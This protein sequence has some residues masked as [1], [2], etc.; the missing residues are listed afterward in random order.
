MKRFIF[1]VFLLL[2]SACSFAQIDSPDFVDS[3]HHALQ[4]AKDTDRVIILGEL[5]V[6]YA[7]YKPDSSFNFAKEGLQLSEQLHYKK[8]IAIS[9]IRLAACFRSTGS[10]AQAMQYARRALPIF[11]ELKDVDNVALCNLMMNWVYFDQEM[12][13]SAFSYT[14]KATNLL[15]NTNSYMLYWCYTSFMRLYY[16]ENMLDSVIVYAE[17]A[18]NVSHTIDPLQM[19]GQVYTQKHDTAKAITYYKEALS[20]RESDMY[21][22]H[23]AQLKGNNDSAVFYAKKRLADAM[24]RK[25]LQ[26]VTNA[27]AFLF[28]I[29]SSEHKSDS[30]LK[31]ILIS[32]HAKDSLFS[33]EK[34]RQFQTAVYS[35]AM[36]RQEQI[37]QQESDASKRKI[38]I[39]ISIAAIIILIAFFL[40]RSNRQKQKANTLLY[41]QKNEIEQQRQKAENAL[42]E[43]KS[44]QT[45]LIQSEKMASL[46]ELTAGIAH[47]IQNPLNFVNN[48]SEVNKEMVDELQLE[49]KSGNIEDAIAISNDIKENSEK[50]NHHGKRADAIVKNMLQHSRKSS[51]KKEPTDINA[52]CDEYLRLSYHGLR[53][54]NKEFN[55]EIKTDFDESIGKINIVPQDIGRVLLNLFNNAFYAV[56]EKFTANRSRLTDNY[57]PLVSV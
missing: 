25:F 17:K 40:Y 6:N 5:A 18:Y 43:L 56:N 48:F 53:A 10:S 38:Y 22:A 31:Y 35:E 37:T 34:F 32:Q 28:D 52:L 45:Q 11:E 21:R 33:R 36:Q 9:L 44:T 7:F 39:L 8:G 26:D 4:T 46:G 15:A 47:E 3:L 54:K 1:L 23:I 41:Q 19:L 12:Y 14:K 55:A 57:K 42:A 50:I 27:S 29:Y 24:Q 13:D 51:G 30:A 20:I 49:L 2:Q 16:N